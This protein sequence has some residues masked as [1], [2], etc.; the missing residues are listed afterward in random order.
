MPFIKSLPANAKLAEL[1]KPRGKYYAPL[2]QFLQ[3]VMRGDSELTPGQREMIAGYV[4]SL[5]H[6]RYCEGGHREAALAL[7]IEPGVFD[8]LKGD[9]ETAEVDDRLKPILNFARKLTKAPESVTQADA[10]AIIA[11][12]W[13]EDTLS[14]VVNVCA[15]FNYFNRLVEGHGIVG[16]EDEFQARGEAHA[17]AGYVKQYRHE[18]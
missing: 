18:D 6:C 14:D 15:I 9:L 7:G 8:A 2:L 4:S 13:S 1:F 17:K 5:N 11:A 10:D 12:G 3:G 16:I